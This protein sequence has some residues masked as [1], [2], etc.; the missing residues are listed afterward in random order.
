MF[1]AAGKLHTQ[2]PRLRSRFLSG[3]FAA[4][5]HCHVNCLCNFHATS[6]IH[7]IHSL[8]Q[9]KA[10]AWEH[11]V[12]CLANQTYAFLTSHYVNTVSLSLRDWALRISFTC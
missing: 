3:S 7:F 6:I 12:V 11:V 9:F 1:T 5:S 2:F 8:G 4:L 10:T